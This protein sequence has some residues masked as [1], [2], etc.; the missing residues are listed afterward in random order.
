MCTM[1]LEVDAMM[2]VQSDGAGMGVL[3]LMQCWWRFFKPQVAN[4]FKVVPFQINASFFEAIHLHET[5]IN[6]FIRK[7]VF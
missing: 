4:D 2:N 1:L 3:E 6:W 5:W 7:H